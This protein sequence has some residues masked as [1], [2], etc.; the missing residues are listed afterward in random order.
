MELML[1]EAVE[2][3]AGVLDELSSLRLKFEIVKKGGDEL[4]VMAEE[5][6]C[7]F[8]EVAMRLN[9]QFIYLNEDVFTL[10]RFIQS[11]EINVNS[12]SDTLI[13]II[14]PQEDANFLDDIPYQEKIQRYFEHLPVKNLRAELIEKLSGSLSGASLELLNNSGNIAS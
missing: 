9:R 6:D 14:I 3:I 7:S 13:K 11:A 4:C 5:L 12:I 2:R 8:N 10:I 1:K